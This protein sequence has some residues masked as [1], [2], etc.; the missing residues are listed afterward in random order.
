MPSHRRSNHLPKSFRS[1]ELLGWFE[2]AHVIDKPAV[3]RVLTTL[4]N[5]EE[6]DADLRNRAILVPHMPM[7]KPT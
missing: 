2:E 7:K 3:S 1:D 4:A 5:V 6:R